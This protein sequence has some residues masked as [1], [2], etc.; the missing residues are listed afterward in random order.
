MKYTVHQ[1]RKDRK[2][3]KEA[4]ATQLQQ[5][6]NN[7]QLLENTISTQNSQIEEQ[8]QKQQETHRYLALAL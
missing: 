5:A 6:M 8:L 3:E 7:Q 1:I 4:M 2:S